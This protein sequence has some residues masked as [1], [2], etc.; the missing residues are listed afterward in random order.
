MSTV[1]LEDYG[2]T[3]SEVLE[4][5]AKKRKNREWLRKHMADLKKRFAGLYIAVSDGEV[6]GSAEDLPTLFKRLREQGYDQEEISTFA[7][8]LITKEDVIWIF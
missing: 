8:D 1:L 2:L 7:I 5:L 4:K 3:R 6:R